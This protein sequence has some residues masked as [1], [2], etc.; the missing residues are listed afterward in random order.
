MV[1]LATR[2]V[3]AERVRAQLP[4]A[5][6]VAID[7]Q[8]QW[9]LFGALGPA[10]GDFVPSDQ[11]TTLGGVGRTPYWAVWKEVLK[12]AVGDTAGGI[13]GVVPVLRSMKGLLDSIDQAVNDEDVGA[14]EDI[15]DS[16]AQATLDQAGADLTLILQ[17]FSDPLRLLLLGQLMGSASRPRIDDTINLVPPG[18]W[19]GRDWLH[20]RSTGTFVAALRQRADGS[21]DERL[22]AYSRGWQVTYAALTAASGFVDSAVGSVYRTHWWRHRW[23]SNFVDAWVWGYYDVGA[24]MA[25]DIPTPP[26][27]DW[28][29]VCSANL[30]DLVNVSGG[31]V[32]HEANAK[33]I[34]DETPLPHL[35]PT[36]FTGY[37]LAAFGDAYGTGGVPPFSDDTLQKGYAALLTVL[38]FQSSGAVIGCNPLPGSPPGTCGSGGPPDWVNPTQTNPVTGQPFLPQPPSPEADPDVAEIVSGIILALLGIV[39][40]AFGG[41]AVGAAAIVGGIVMIVDGAMQP[42]WDDLRCDVY[43]LKVYLFNGLTALHNLT[44]L[45]GVQHPYGRD[46]A[47]DELVLSFGDASLPYTSG[48]AVAKSKG[49]DGLRQPWGGTLSTW[50]SPPTEP[51][52]SQLTDVWGRPG[53][54]P[55]ALVDDDVANPLDIAVADPPGTWPGGVKGYFGPAVQAALLLYAD[56]RTDLPSWNLDADRGRGWLTWQLRAPY[57]VPV[58]PV[59]EP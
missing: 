58:A 52:E 14:L 35:L 31:G 59:P 4:A 38:W 54:W 48:A 5:D 55:S 56:D 46:L 36:D 51:S 45:G 34:A 1:G 3:I 17:Q 53:L 41:W 6:R 23:V 26:F 57:A 12:I 43:W 19:T 47:V 24:S 11:A 2:L 42:D 28:T 8:P 44:V 50:T 25:G 16:G 32:D 15:V 13:P 29:G 21:G 33:A 30:Q 40:C 18:L 7:H 20:W 37:W 39:A 9:Y 22:I 27:A 10:I 49:I